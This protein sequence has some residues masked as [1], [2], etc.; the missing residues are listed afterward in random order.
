MDLTTLRA[1][2]LPRQRSELVFGKGAAPLGG[3]TWLFSERQDHLTELVDLTALAW[4]PWAEE[5]DGSLTVA[6]TCTLAELLRIPERPEW[7]ALSLIPR[8]VDSLVAS[9]KIWHTAT[10]GGNLA[11]ALPAG[12][13]TS[14]ATALDAEA[15]LWTADGERRMPAADLVLGVRRTAL[16]PGEV[17]RSLTFPA[18]SLAARTAFR[19]VALSPLG[20]AGTVVIGRRDA[21]G[22]VTIGVTGGTERPEILRFPALPTDAELSAAID[23]IDTWYDDPHGAP[24]WREAMSRRFAEEIRKE[25]A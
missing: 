21:D 2:R 14:L 1:V 20:R 3:G 23:G 5:P 22:A 16:E 19:R 4:E 15:V 18:G 11:L 17:I 7:P 6:A 9:F 8:C 24:D 10:I 13:L 12:G 25:L